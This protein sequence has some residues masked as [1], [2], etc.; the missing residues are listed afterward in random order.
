MTDLESAARRA[1]VVEALGVLGSGPEERFDR[2]TRMTQEA[3]GV[4]LSFLN[5]VHDGLVTAQSTQGWNQGQSVPAEWV[6]CATTVLTPE[7]LVVPD[8]VLDERFRH[9]PAVTDEG[10]RFY[11][12]APLS[13]L[14]G[15]RVG[16]LCIMDAAPRTFSDEDL[17]LLGDLARWAERELGQAIDRGRVRRVLDGLV[18]EPVVVPGHDLA[19]LVT[20]REDGGGDVADWRLVAEDVLHVTVGRVAAPGRAA[21]LLAAGVRGA[22]VARTDTALPDAV[23]GL[24][25]QVTSDLSTG[26]AVG[27]LFHLRLDTTSG[28]ADFADA[29]HG[30]AVLVRADGSSRALHSLDL[31]MGLQPDAVPRSSGAIDL[32]PGDRLA[33]C[34][35][36]VL[37]LDGIGHLDALADLVRSAPDGAAVVDH[38]RTL[39][40]AGEPAHDVTLVVL[41]RR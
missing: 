35:P 26:G 31:P 23:A 33:I 21:G 36:G 39:L 16:T 32:G 22:V 38:V 1:A 15:T 29:G 11:A 6:F 12:G 13:M 5:L 20:Q 7:P 10:I 27:S 30:L 17:A 24:E 34:T 9:M 8:T 40:P 14:D 18:P 37:A 19:T 3:F 41:T 28:H 4:P 25:A 2:I